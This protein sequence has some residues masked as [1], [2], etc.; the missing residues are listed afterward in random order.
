MAAKL[1]RM[2]GVMAA[3]VKPAAEPP[4]APPS[5]GGVE[6]VIA[7]ALVDAPPVTPDFTARQGYLRAATQGV[8]ADWAATQPGG[9]GDGSGIIDIEG[10]W[11]FSHEDLL[12]NQGGV[13]GRHAVADSAGV[14]H[15]SAVIGRDWRRSTRGSASPASVP[16]RISR[17][18][19]TGASD[20][21]RPSSSPRR[22]CSRATSSC[23]RC[24]GRARGSIS[25]TGGSARLHRRRMVAGRLRGHS[26]RGRSRHHRRRSGGQRRRVARRCGVR[27][28]RHRV[29]KDV[30]QPVQTRRRGT[31]ARSSSAPARR[32]RARTAATMGPTGRGWISRT[33]GR[34]STRRAGGA[35]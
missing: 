1:A 26:L 24:T 20:P 7:A 3:Y 27:Q 33:T 8:D 12:Q 18:S 2:P 4:L 21:R 22:C 19:P 28:S 17:P 11:N 5:A 10:G 23:S 30:A 25:R 29:S 13:I 31:R 32:R 15:G 6:P 14:N 9:L 16:R 34:A 35:K